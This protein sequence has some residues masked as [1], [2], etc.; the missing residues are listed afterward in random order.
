MSNDEIRELAKQAGFKWGFLK[1]E[2]LMDGFIDFAHLVAQLEREACEK[3]C[4]IQASIGNDDER[5]GAR[6]CGYAIRARGIKHD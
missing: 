2:G 6:Q 3:E 1:E 4:Y 5:F